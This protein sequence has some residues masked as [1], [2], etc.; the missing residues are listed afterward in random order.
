MFSTGVCH[1]H[2]SI[3]F[4]IRVCHVLYWRILHSVLEFLIQDRSIP[5]SELQYSILICVQT[6]EAV[7]VVYWRILHLVLEYF[8]FRTGVFHVQSWSSPY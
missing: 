6:S 4:I 2:L 1:I 8:L 3:L 7:H 5:C